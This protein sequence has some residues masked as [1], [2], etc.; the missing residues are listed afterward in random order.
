MILV[1]L[2]GLVSSVMAQVVVSPA[3]PTV[4][5]GTTRQF[6]ATGGT[7]PYTYSLASGSAGSITSGGLYTPP[8]TVTVKQAVGGCQMLPPDHIFNTRIDSLPLHSSNTALMALLTANV[9]FEVSFGTNVLTNATGT[10]SLVTAYTT[11]NDGLYQ[12]AA[13]PALKRESGVFTPP[14]GGLDRHVIGV[15]RET[16]EFNDVY[17]DYAVGDNGPAQNNCPTCT[18]QSAVK[19]NGYDHILPTTG[20]TDAA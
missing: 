12:M 18:A 10:K 4:T 6:S 9:S 3:T 15:N 14:F 2:V 19:Y 16:C 17:N 5:Q 8:A 20:A 1:L 11:P 7:G 13:W